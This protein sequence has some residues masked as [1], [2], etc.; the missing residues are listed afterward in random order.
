MARFWSWGIGLALSGSLLLVGCGG[1]P[2]GDD[3][4]TGS[5]DALTAKAE[6]ANTK[7]PIVLC[8]GMAGFDTLFGVLDYWYEIPSALRAAGAD[9]YVTK[10]PSFNSSEARGEALLEQVEEITARTGKAKVNLIGHSHGGFDVRYVAAVRPDL[11]ASVTTVGSPHRGADL[12]TFLRN[13]ISKGS[14][15]NDVTGFFGNELGNVLELLSGHSEAQD[16]IGGLDSLTAAGAGLFN[17]KFPAGVPTTTCGSG[18]A[19][20]NG[21]PFYSWAG[22]Q[23]LTNS[24]DVSDTPLSLSSF[25][26]NGDND[27]LVGRCSAHFGT[28]LRDD[29]PMNHLDEVNQVVGLTAVFGTDPVSVFRA[30]ANRLKKQGL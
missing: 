26:Y 15:T 11:V 14:F 18:A 16:A 28:V 29:Y 27:G 20:E 10:V 4:V 24:L 13:H 8:H 5:E 2:D 23:V 6:Y 17:K 22:S 1:A 9:V 3:A 7:Y 25:F 19:K 21:I 12:A 30:H